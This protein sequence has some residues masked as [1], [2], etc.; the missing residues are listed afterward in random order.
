M[1]TDTNAIATE[2]EVIAVTKINNAS[3]TA[4]KCCTKTKAIGFKAYPGS[5]QDYKDNQLVKYSDIYQDRT[6]KIVDTKTDFGVVAVFRKSGQY[7][8]YF[9]LVT[10]TYSDALGSAT[11]ETKIPGNS[12]S[13]LQNLP[14]NY[15]GIS[16][17]DYVKS[18]SDSNAS[19]TYPILPNYTAHYPYNDISSIKLQIRISLYGTTGSI[20]GSNA[21]ANNENLV[22][23]FIRDI[24]TS[25]GGDI[26]L[27]NTR[28]T[29]DS[30][31]EYS[32]DGPYYI[33]NN[34]VF[35]GN[36]HRVVVCYDTQD[37]KNVTKNYVFSGYNV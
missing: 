3:A 29:L 16:S 20:S 28:W 14:S 33:S 25:V 23:T 24:D 19:T 9:L 30:D 1:A 8:D 36:Y 26:Y 37:T 7:T 22:G 6:I 31:D 27:Y 5:L 4:D 35:D 2:Q 10:V 17:M 34:E 21:G 32:Y 12:G 11:R 13:L 18:S 15:V